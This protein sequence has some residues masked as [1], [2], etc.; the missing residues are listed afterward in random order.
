MS[1]LFAESSSSNQEK[2]TVNR[3]LNNLR[4]QIIVVRFRDLTAIKFARLGSYLRRK[5]VYKDFA[6]NL[7]CMHHGATF[8]EQLGLIRHSFQQKIEF[9]SHQ[10]F[11]FPLADLPLD[12]HETFAPLLDLS[13]RE[14]LVQPIRCCAILIGV[15]ECPHP[16]ELGFANE[17]TELFKFFLSLSRKANDERGAQ[18]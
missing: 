11:L 1:E 14:L 8:H 15:G 18:G 17:S 12:S 6:V 2:A 3:R 16:I 13:Q 4:D 10:R 9:L 5:V 7:G